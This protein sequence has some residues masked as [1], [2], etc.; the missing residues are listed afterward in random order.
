MQHDALQKSIGMLSQ[1]NWLL[2]FKFIDFLL[3]EQQK[4]IVPPSE[5]KTLTFLEHI[6]HMNETV[7]GDTFACDAIE[8]RSL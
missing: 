3:Y 2:D 5:K 7:C 6:T 1:A 8:M 4:S